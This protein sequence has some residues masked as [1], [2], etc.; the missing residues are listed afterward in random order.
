MGF[1][2][3]FVFVSGF[4]LGSVRCGVSGDFCTTML[5]FLSV[6]V[7]LCWMFIN[8]ANVVAELLCIY[9]RSSAAA[10]LRWHLTVSGALALG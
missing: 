4:G 1:V 2:F 3:S 5:F 8:S 6:S 9:R 7:V 10:F